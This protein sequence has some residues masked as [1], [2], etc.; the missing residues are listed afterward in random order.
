MICVVSLV[1]YVCLTSHMEKQKNYL[2]RQEKMY[3]MRKNVNL[4]CDIKVNLWD[5]SVVPNDAWPPLGVWCNAQSPT[6][7][8]VHMFTSVIGALFRKNGSIFFLHS[9]IWPSEI[10]LQPISKLWLF[11][12]QKIGDFIVYWS[13]NISTSFVTIWATL[14]ITAL[15]EDKAKAF[16]HHLWKSP[17]WEF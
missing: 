9:I 4:C 12:T 6:C 13:K 8:P 17:Q 11:R 2:T 7:T 5:C 3:L 14:W 16:L 10:I 15:Y 1:W